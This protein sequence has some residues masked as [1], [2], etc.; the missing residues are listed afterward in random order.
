M[1]R[2]FGFSFVALLVG[3]IGAGLDVGI[4]HAQSAN[5]PPTPTT[6]ILAIGTLNPGVCRSTCDPAD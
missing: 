6:K 1:K 4:G 5:P 3:L 2:A